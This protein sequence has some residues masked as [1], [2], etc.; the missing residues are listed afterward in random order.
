MKWRP[1]S[2]MDVTMVIRL[3]RDTTVS[4]WTR[5]RDPVSLFLPHP[6]AREGKKQQ[7]L[8]SSRALR[9]DAAPGSA[10]QD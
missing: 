10:V 7:E 6:L 4:G 3:R 9:D 5:P 1:G 2:V 8:Q